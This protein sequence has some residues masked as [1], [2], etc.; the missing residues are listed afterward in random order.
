MSGRSSL[1][2]LWFSQ[3][4]RHKNYIYIYIYVYIYIYIQY[5]VKTA[6]HFL[7][8]VIDFHVF[9]VKCKAV[10]CNFKAFLSKNYKNE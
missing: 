1:Y 10:K 2:D 7:A 6:G 3:T 4:L 5:V 9:F 8:R